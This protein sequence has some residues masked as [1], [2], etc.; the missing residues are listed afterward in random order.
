MEHK[1]A[2]YTLHVMEHKEVWYT[3]HV[4]EHK[5]VWYTLLVME[6]Q[7]SPIYPTCDETA[8]TPGTPYT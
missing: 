5:E 2:W 1:E 3:L 6:Q 4:M 8:K 7:R